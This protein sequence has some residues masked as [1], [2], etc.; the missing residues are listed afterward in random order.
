MFVV[1]IG[2]Y[3]NDA[4]RGFESRL[5]RFR[6]GKE[7]EHGIGPIDMPIDRVLTG[8]HIPCETR[9]DDRDWLLI[10]VVERVEIAAGNDGN[11]ERCEKAGRDGPPLRARIVFSM[12]VTITRELQTYGK[13]F[14][15]T[16]WSD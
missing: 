9:A 4:V 8:K 15:I 7:L 12:D 11:A 3:A 6:P 10:L 16:P 2:G 1:H 5:V 14:G 13:P